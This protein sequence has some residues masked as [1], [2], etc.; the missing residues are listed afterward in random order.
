[1]WRPSPVCGH[2]FAATQPGRAVI[3]SVEAARPYR[4]LGSL[5]DLAERESD[6]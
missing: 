6:P 1:M 2:Y 4:P 5:R 3:D